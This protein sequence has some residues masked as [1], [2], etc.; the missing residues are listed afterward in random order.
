[1]FKVN[2]IYEEYLDLV[3]HNLKRFITRLRISAYSLR[4]HTGRV[5]VIRLPD[6]NDCV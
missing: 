5:G 3:P 2:F 4:I 1:M 6:I